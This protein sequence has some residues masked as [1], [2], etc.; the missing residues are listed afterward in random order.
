MRI[1]NYNERRPRSSANVAS[2]RAHETV[3]VRTEQPLAVG[4]L[5]TR[6]RADNGGQ[7]LADEVRKLSRR[8]EDATKKRRI[9]ESVVDD[10]ADALSFA[11]VRDM[12]AFQDK[13]DFEVAFK[14]E[15]GR[16]ITTSAFS[17]LASSMAFADVQVA[18]E[19][20]PTVVERMVT[21]L[22]DKQP[23]TELGRPLDFGHQSPSAEPKPLGETEEYHEA[24]DVDEER[25]T[26][27]AFKD[28]YQRAFSQ[29][30]IDLG[31]P[32]V[33]SELSDL[34]AGAREIMEFN[35]LKKLIDYHGSKGSSQTS[36]VMI[37]NR[38]AASLF[39][40]TANTPS[41]R[42]PSGTRVVNN[43]L[44]DGTSLSNLRTRLAAMR[45]ARL[46]PIANWPEV[47]LVPDALW[48][49]A[50]ATLMS[51]LVPSVENETNFWGPNGPGGPIELISTPMLDL[52]T[53]T[54]WY[55]GRPRRQ[56]VRKWKMRPEVA[57]YGGRGTE[58]FLRTR[59]G[60]RV[61][62]GWDMTLGVRAHE[63]W[64][65]CLSASTPP[66]GA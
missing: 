16:S 27:L 19:G 23:H 28:G 15:R 55:G 13:L 36:H 20:V 4:E 18:Y 25:Y 47:L 3:L 34:G 40:A 26:I 29:E 37:R 30:V 62:I 7:W 63:Y 56:F 12:R 8:R 35:S 6:A 2:L 61:R 42:T 38:A 58:S 31:G 60:M 41:T 43:A 66:G 24:K 53:T 5:V 1:L 44:V 39:S 11:S 10:E 46:Y 51:V 57:V 9:G 50:H 32:R 65:E 54:A 22:D 49:R 64:V 48:E 52:L 21:D 45:N 17:L 33:F 14:D 59:E